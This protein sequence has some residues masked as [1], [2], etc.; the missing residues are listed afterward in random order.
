MYAH[1]IVITAEKNEKTGKTRGDLV[2]TETSICY[3]MSANLLVE[4][5]HDNDAVR[6]HLNRYYSPHS[7]AS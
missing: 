3:C 7:F 4:R 6:L 1:V 2:S 5:Q